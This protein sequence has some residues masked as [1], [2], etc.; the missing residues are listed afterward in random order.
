M[1]KEVKE[2]VT[3]KVE[4]VISRKHYCDKCGEEIVRDG[5]F[6]RE[7]SKIVF[8]DGDVFPEGG[9]IDYEEA[10]FCMECRELVKTVLLGIGV[11]FT[12]RTLEF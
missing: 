10:Y 5:S 4:R 2:I 11:T 8:Q 12:K 3:V 1:I 9:Y 6:S 7:V